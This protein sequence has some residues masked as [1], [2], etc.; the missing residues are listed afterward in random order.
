MAP[1][2]NEFRNIIGQIDFHAWRIDII[3]KLLE[4]MDFDRSGISTREF[5]REYFER[6]DL[7][8]LICVGQQLQQVRR[9][10]QERTTPLLL[11]NEH[12]L[13]YVVHPD[14]SARARQFIVNRTQRMLNMYMRLGNY[15]E[16]GQGTYQLPATDRLIERI[17]GTASEMR[18]L[19]QALG[20]DEDDPAN[21]P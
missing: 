10:L 16:I 6:E 20:P 9:M 11:L 18:Q 14:D 19:E 21:T 2:I 8:I 7:E 3:D 13:W 15:A 5:S 1:R 4:R 12:R 17:E